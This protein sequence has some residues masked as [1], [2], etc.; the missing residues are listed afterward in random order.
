MSPA[1]IAA[2][3]RG[4]VAPAGASE[5]GAPRARTGAA[6]TA[7]VKISTLTSRRTLVG[8]RAAGNYETRGAH[9]EQAEVFDYVFHY[10][11]HLNGTRSLA[12]EYGNLNFNSAAFC[13]ANSRVRAVAG[14]FIPLSW[15]QTRQRPVT[16]A[17]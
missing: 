7:V 15:P 11:F 13:G 9:S 2:A 10:V 1:L 5:T 16:S 4:S 12:G 6:S 3:S 14:R 8:I 17:R